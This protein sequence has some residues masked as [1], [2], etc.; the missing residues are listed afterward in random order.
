M[1]EI[2]INFDNLKKLSSKQREKEI[3]EIRKCLD[4]VLAIE[5]NKIKTAKR[6]IKF[7]WI[8][9]FILIGSAIL[10]ILADNEFALMLV[11]GCLICTLFTIK[12]WNEDFEEY[13]ENANSIIN[14]INDLEKIID[15][16][17]D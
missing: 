2:E 5:N 10:D 8:F 6:I 3:A 13:K 12:N 15:E 4:K 9:S 7:N 14:A 17:E 11:S 16:L 1:I